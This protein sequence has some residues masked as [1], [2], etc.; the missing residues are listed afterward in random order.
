M[1]PTRQSTSTL[2]FAAHSLNLKLTHS[3]TFSFFQVQL[4]VN[5][6]IGVLMLYSQLKFHFQERNV[7]HCAHVN[8]TSIHSETASTSFSNV[9]EPG[10]KTIQAIHEQS[11][12]PDDRNL[13]DAK[14]S[15]LRVNA[16][17]ASLGL[18]ASPSH[19]TIMFS[20][21]FILQSKLSRVLVQV[22]VYD[23]SDWFYFE[24]LN[25]AYNARLPLRRACVI[26]CF[27]KQ[28]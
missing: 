22:V 19:N 18:F 4:K 17:W 25:L 13:G 26:R 2:F 5:K 12:Q 21:T 20:L 23:F 15:S 28:W 7:L 11:M 8:V 3:L 1:T 6:R 27:R 9:K 24:K 10:N 16:I 14:A